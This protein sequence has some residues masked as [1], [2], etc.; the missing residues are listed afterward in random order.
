M[1]LKDLIGMNVG[2]SGQTPLV[3]GATPPNVADPKQS[4]PR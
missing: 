2:F 1:I 3:L 4:D